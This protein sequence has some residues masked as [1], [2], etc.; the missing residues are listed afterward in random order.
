MQGSGS[1]SSR[2]SS[3]YYPRSVRIHGTRL[4][5]FSHKIL[6]SEYKVSVKI[7][8]EHEKITIFLLGLV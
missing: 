3:K 6:S 4:S 8:C 2:L 5:S 7:V 1:R